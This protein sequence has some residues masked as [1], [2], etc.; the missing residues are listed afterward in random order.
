MNY[1]IEG[2]NLPVVLIDLEAGEEITCE[3]GA[4]SW[5]DDEIEM[6]TEAGGLGKMFGRLLTNESAFLNHYVA[7]RDG[8]IAFS[9]HFPGSI[10]AIEVTPDRPII[11][12]KG[13]FLAY[14]GNIERTVFMQKRIGSGLFGGEGF[15]MHRFSGTGVV[16][17]EIDGSAIEYEIAAGDKK[18]VDT[19]Y[20]A[21]M[22]ESCSLDIRQVKGVK[23]VLFG[24]EGLFN[25]EISGPG[26]VLLQTM[27][28]SKTAMLLYQYM[29]HPS[30]N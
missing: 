21:V 7:H 6:R 15:L 10:M 22:D 28:C 5:M 20:V 12:Q 29:P 24:G 19:G 9:S 26:R 3:A 25:T 30:S 2:D 4:M 16:F 11:V 8:E 14:Y 23:N 17:V 27:P 18:I 1:R 13:S